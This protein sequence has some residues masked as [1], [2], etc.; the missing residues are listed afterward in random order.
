M[1][2]DVQLQPVFG[3][4]SHPAIGVDGIF[5]AGG[6]T[7]WAINPGAPIQVSPIVWM[8]RTIINPRSPPAIGAD[9]TIYVGVRT[10]LYAFN[11]DGSTKWT[12]TS[13]TNDVDAQP[14]IGNDAVY[15]RGGP[16]PTPFGSYWILYVL[17]TDGTKRW[18]FARPGERYSTPVVSA[19]GVI[20]LSSSTNLYALN[21]DGSVRWSFAT[22]PYFV[23]QPLPTALGFRSP[24][25]GSEGRI[26]ITT[27]TN[28]YAVNPDGSKA[29]VFNRA[30]SL[31]SAPII[32]D[33]GTIYV[34]GHPKFYAI[35]GST[36]SLRHPWPMIG[37]DA[38]HTSRSLQRGIAVRQLPGQAEII[39]RLLLELNRSYQVESS[40]DFK[41]WTTFTNVLSTNAIVEVRDLKGSGTGQRYYRLQ[42]R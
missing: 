31:F 29:W 35:Q 36:G 14:V 27:P 16:A 5:Y 28:L 18:E 12:F 32:S 39:L 9:G 41:S 38:Q 6:P 22:K 8:I 37:H 40:Q 17:N 23:L 7:F 21:P 19:D 13:Q 2:A 26:Y 24:S 33:D 34:G 3:P 1:D 20:Y 25:L 10:N 42:M 4:I 15:V 30:D 11:R